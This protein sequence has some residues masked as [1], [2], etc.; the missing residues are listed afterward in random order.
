MI[1]KILRK[2]SYQMKKTDYPDR[3]L[4]PAVFH[5]DGA[6]KEIAVVFPDLDCAT[7]GVDEA[8]ALFSARELLGSR[9]ALMEELGYEIPAASRLSD[10]PAGENEKTALIDVYMP[11]IRM[12]N[13]TRAVSRTVT[14]PAWLNAAALERSV[15]FSQVLQEA[16]KEL[17]NVQAPIAG[18]D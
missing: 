4:Y 10:L 2:V 11:A 5:Y 8:D 14:L 6:G 1:P 7:S 12:V 16:L 18:G 15:N 3:Y 13:V 9:L 17:L